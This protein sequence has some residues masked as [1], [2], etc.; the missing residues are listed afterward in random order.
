MI[1]KQFVLQV[2]PIES[3]FTQARCPTL[4]GCHINVNSR[5]S[6]DVDKSSDSGDSCDKHLFSGLYFRIIGVDDFAVKSLHTL[7]SEHGGELLY[8]LGATPCNI[9]LCILKIESP[10][11]SKFVRLSTI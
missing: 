1:S 10:C 3:P 8:W 2:L 4:A 9:I 11:E 5:I 6:S 7:I